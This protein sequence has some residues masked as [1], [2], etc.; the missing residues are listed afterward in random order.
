MAVPERDLP[1]LNVWLALADP[2][3]QFHGRARRYW[4][5]ESASRLF[6]CRVSMLGLLRLLSNPR[7]MRGNPFTP[8]EAWAAYRSFLALPE[9]S[10]LAESSPAE[11]RFAEWTDSAD[12]APQRWTDAWLATQAVTSQARL[13]SFD[14][15]FHT[16]PG[17]SFL[18]LTPLPN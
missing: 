17:L 7:V 1:D 2:D 11:A 9:V 14:S 5:T 4:E 10:F 6:F 8:A 13:V 15:D 3:H 18:H 12:F 16:F